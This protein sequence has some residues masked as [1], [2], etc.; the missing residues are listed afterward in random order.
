MC[1]V[2]GCGPDQVQ[3]S[4][5]VLSLCNAKLTGVPKDKVQRKIT[6]HGGGTFR[7]V[8]GSKKDSNK[9]GGTKRRFRGEESLEIGDRPVK[10]MRR[11]STA[12][13]K[14]FVMKEVLKVNPSEFPKELH[15]GKDTDPAQPGDYERCFAPVGSSI[16]PQSAVDQKYQ[17]IILIPLADVP[18]NM[19][20]CIVCGEMGDLTDCANCPRSYHA[21]CLVKDRGDADEETECPRCKL[22][23]KVSAE[24][25]EALLNL[26]MN[27]H[28]KETYG[29]F[30]HE[31]KLLEL[32]VQIVRKL[33][34]YDFGDIFAEPVNTDFVPNYLETIKTPMDYRTLIEKLEGGMYPNASIEFTKEMNEIETI[35]LHVLCDIEQVH[36][37]CLFYN[38]KSSN[39]YRIGYVHSIKW[40]A[41][42]K[43]HI[44]GSLSD[45]VKANLEEF[46]A[47][48]KT[49][50]ETQVRTL[51]GTKPGNK[52]S[53]EIGVFDPDTKK[54][55]KIYTSKAA[56]IRAADAL[57]LAGYECEFELEERSW[58]TI[59]DK[60]TLHDSTA[61]LFGY[62]WI[63]MESLRSGQFSLDGKADGSTEKV[64]I[65]KQDTVSDQKLQGFSSDEAAYND[66]LVVRS[67]AISI[68]PSIGEDMASF[69]QHYVDRSNTINGIAWNR[70]AAPVTDTVS[71][72]ELVTQQ[73]T[74]L[75]GEQ[76]GRL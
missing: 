19:D 17:D 40:K 65:W 29:T 25:D 4:G 35:I 73:D 26:P 8:G 1:E 56:A 7:G 33:T 64:V 31:S 36:H 16:P 67:T 49:I 62:R 34:V 48:C 44:S 53:N 75:M 37:N 66:W 24:E 20:Y 10:K 61:L 15:E 72:E 71:S 51:D 38:Q 32:I 11:S 70:V 42:Y 23:S 54:V 76:A 30:A 60:I 52:C 63:P 59:M 74:V 55:V 69:K 22:D 68:D 3:M 28:I 43:K 14:S 45:N 6:P 41:Y 27:T 18:S 9:S 50:Q 5:G 2:Q 58:K 21:E 47:K 39:Y 57:K 12:S 13:L 46:R